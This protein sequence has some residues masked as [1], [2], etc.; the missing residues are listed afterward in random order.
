MPYPPNKGD[1]IRAFHQLRAM[2]AR[3]E[4]DVFTLVD[5]AGDL[6]YQEPLA[7]HCHQLTV[8]RVH[9]KM[10]RLRALRFL[11]TQK[12]LTVPY[13]YSAELQA[14]VRRALLRRSYDRI[15]VYCSAMAQYVES[16][17]QIPMV[18]EF[19]V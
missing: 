3:H 11:T 13:F 15:F 2:A 8:A 16:A 10:A 7:G 18:T 5:D 19:V 12:P 9:P 1:K 4:V 17:G 6:A 14:E